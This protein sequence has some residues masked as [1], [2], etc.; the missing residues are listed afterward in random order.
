MGE[1]PIIETS[2]E[3]KLRQTTD[4]EYNISKMPL[5]PLLLIRVFT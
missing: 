1:E 3:S 2:R 4:V 5:L